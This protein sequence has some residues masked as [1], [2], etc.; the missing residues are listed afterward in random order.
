MFGALGC[1]AR[2]ALF[3]ACIVD[4]IG[5]HIEA[6]KSGAD[7]SWEFMVSKNR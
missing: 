5:F 2:E 6:F 3:A 4:D 1:I 7:I